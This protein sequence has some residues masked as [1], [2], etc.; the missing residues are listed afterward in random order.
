[1]CGG[2]PHQEIRLRSYVDLTLEVP[3]APST[4]CAR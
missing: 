1:M 4:C 3:D 2:V